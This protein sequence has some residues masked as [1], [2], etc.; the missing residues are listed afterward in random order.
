MLSLLSSK[1]S[2][3]IH[4]LALHLEQHGL[5][6]QAAVCLSLLDSSLELNHG[7]LSFLA[8]PVTDVALTQKEMSGC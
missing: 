2:M 4:A 7:V 8:E 6:D 5:A 3:V 1:L